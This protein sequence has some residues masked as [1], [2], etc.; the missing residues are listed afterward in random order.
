MQQLVDAVKN[1]SLLV[2]AGMVSLMKLKEFVETSMRERSRDQQ[3]GD[4]IIRHFDCAWQEAES[5]AAALSIDLYQSLSASFK[6]DQL[7]RQLEQITKRL[8]RPKDTSIAEI[9]PESELDQTSSVP[10]KSNESQISIDERTASKDF[11]QSKENKLKVWQ[12]IKI[13]GKLFA[14]SCMIKRCFL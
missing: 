2:T 13:E 11:F 1:V 5:M 3:A 8:Q 7:M 9:E 4:S 12:Q 6:V 14:T 10:L